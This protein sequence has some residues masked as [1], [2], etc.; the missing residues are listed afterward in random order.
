MK[1][2]LDIVLYNKI[3]LTS[4]STLHCL[5]PRA[6]SKTSEDQLSIVGSESLYQGEK[7]SF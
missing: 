4:E 6:S 7:R 1:I 2:R 3:Q 5:A